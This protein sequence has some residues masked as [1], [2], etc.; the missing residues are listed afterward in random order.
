MMSHT[1]ANKPDPA[2]ENCY[3]LFDQGKTPELLSVL[4]LPNE[5]SLKLSV[6][7]KKELPV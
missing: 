6:T 1:I 2:W 5:I 4:A 7:A 3:R